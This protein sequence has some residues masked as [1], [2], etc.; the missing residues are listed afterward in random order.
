MN[1]NI[2]KNMTK[3]LLY[4]DFE[5][6][7]DSSIG[8]DL[9]SMS[10]VEY[11]NDPRFKV[12]GCGVQ[13]NDRQPEWIPG[14]DLRDFFNDDFSEDIIVAHNV[15][16]DGAI[17]AWKYGIQPLE[18][19][20]T[21]SMAMAVYGASVPSFSLK[22]LSERLG[23]EP[24]GIMKTNGLQTLNEAEES[25]LASYCLTDVKICAKLYQ[26]LAPKI[27]PSQWAIMDWTIRAFVE[28]KLQVN[29]EAVKKVQADIEKRKAAVLADSSL[30]PKVLASN[31][32]F[33]EYLKQKGYELP[34][35]K[36]PKG[37]LIP[38]LALGDPEFVAMTQSKDPQLR[39][40]CLARKEVKKTMEVKRA[41]KLQAVGKAY[42]FDVIF[43]GA[44]QTHRFSGGSGAGGNPQNFPR[45]SELRRAIEAPEGSKLIVGDFKNIEMRILAFL[46]REP[47]LIQAIR[48]KR[49]VYKE[50]AAKVYKIAADQVTEKQRQFGKCLGEGTLVV[51]NNGI[52]QI[53]TITT[54]D[55]VWDGEQWVT[56]QG[57]IH[58][59]IKEAVGLAGLWLTPDHRILCGTR[60]KEAQ[61]AAQDE[62]TLFRALE[63]GS[64]KLPLLGTLKGNVTGWSR[65]CAS[66]PAEARSN[67]L[68]STTLSPGEQRAVTS[69]QK[70]Q[71][72]QN[73]IGNMQQ[74]C[75]MMTIGLEYLTA[76]LQRLL[77]VTIRTTEPTR[78]TGVEAYLCG[79]DL[80]TTDLSSLVMCRRLKDGTIQVLNSI[81]WMSTKDTNQAISAL[82][83][84]KK[85]SITGGNSEILKKKLPVY[86]LL[87]A[88]PRNRFTVLT[89]A[90]PIIVH[91]CAIL[92][93]GYGMGPKK[94]STT[95]K[96]QGFDISEKMAKDTVYLYRETYSHIPNFWKICEVVIGM[97][98]KG[99]QGFFPGVP[100]LKV[101]SNG[102]ILPSGLEI[103]FPNLRKEEDEWVYDKYKSQVTK[104][105]KA[106]LY[107][108]KLTE[109]IC[110]ALAGEICKVSI[111]RLITA[112]YS[113]Q[114]Q[115]HD[116][117]MLV[118]P[119][120]NESQG[121]VALKS[122]MT[123]P[124]P[125]FMDLKLEAE[126][127]IGA[128]WWDAE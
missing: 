62:S 11:I 38:A 124:I 85:I 22:A 122:A 73:G 48:E 30:D 17:A 6:Y 105:D 125:W 14:K 46:S 89:A 58:N 101:K 9:K 104:T 40:I 76:Y 47:K 56:H 120:Q 107:G 7:H 109:N 77:G 87:S 67:R 119:E 82:L 51:T 71:P 35:K 57:L 98:A 84:E 117:L 95:I 102:L 49:D 88:G 112:G 44:T 66:V 103:K 86:D 121:L 13:I 70:K 28:P 43:S 2:N 60:W 78:T 59:G 106:K 100:F 5:T 83:Q 31:Q 99:Q 52:K 127:G 19:R 18:W 54:N 108:G 27:P 32:Q 69:V 45:E 41:K 91:N 115:V 94:F 26:E 33:A 50:F 116:S 79:A 53:E 20:D 55:K 1:T 110:Q 34:M 25:E 63:K 4:M 36:N 23:F 10:M 29:L 126:I 68:T 24:K 114:G 65:S 61:S 111:Q 128:N 123:D 8:Y 21:K 80:G 74:L 113:P 118:C 12:F 90:G 97:M 3:N 92:G 42:P 39:S 96:L 72:R 64:E 93:L 37:K 15:K 81:E 75:R 16:F